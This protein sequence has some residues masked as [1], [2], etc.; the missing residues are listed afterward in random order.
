MAGG[1]LLNM[2]VMDGLRRIADG[3]IDLVIADPPYGIAKDFGTGDDWNGMD[4]WKLWCQRWLKE[5]HRVLDECGSIMLYGIHNYL[6]FNHVYLYELGMRYRRQIIWH[7]D[8]GFCG[9]RTIRATYEPILWF[10]K[11]DRFTFNEIREPYRSA[12]RLKYEIRKNGK[13]WQP[14][15]DGR[16]AGDVWN[17]PT[18]AGRRFRDERVAHPTQKPLALSERMVR[19]FSPAGGIMLAPFAGSGTECVAAYRLGRS[20]VGIESNQSYCAIARER[21]EAEGWR[22]GGRSRRRV[23]SVNDIVAA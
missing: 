18:L 8:N 12:E 4:E 16:I 21:L 13:V 19:H 2:D 1:K 20:F 11:S 17:F 6:C 10:S 14:N 7:Y 22:L 23:R 3:A 15:P 5:C 9:N